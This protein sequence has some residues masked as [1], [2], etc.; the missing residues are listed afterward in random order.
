MSLPFRVVLA[1]VWYGITHPFASTEEE[2]EASKKI[3]K[4]YKRL[5]KEDHEQREMK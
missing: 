5:F 4:K 2:I 3:C 1:A